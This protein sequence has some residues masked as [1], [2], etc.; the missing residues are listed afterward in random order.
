MTLCAVCH[1]K[2]EGFQ[3]GRIS[4]LTTET[5]K[6]ISEA[7]KGKKIS[8]EHLDKLLKGRIGKPG[9]NKGRKFSLEHRKKLSEAAKRRWQEPQLMT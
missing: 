9:P 2:E 3:K 5:R 8:S 6:K 1:G 4:I 7:H